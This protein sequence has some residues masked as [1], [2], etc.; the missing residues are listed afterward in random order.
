MIDREDYDTTEDYI[1]AR[2]K[3]AGTLPIGTLLALSGKIV[4]ITGSTPKRYKLKMIGDN[5][6]KTGWGGRRGSPGP[7]IW[8]HGTSLAVDK[9]SRYGYRSVLSDLRPFVV[10]DIEALERLAA[11]VRDADRDIERAQE[12]VNQAHEA[13]TKLILGAM[14][15]S[16]GEEAEAI[17]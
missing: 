4:E 1:E 13:R 14:A 10:K 5:P 15:I 6:L 11:L 2:N 9:L 16:R 17:E 7:D 12:A 3:E 8:G